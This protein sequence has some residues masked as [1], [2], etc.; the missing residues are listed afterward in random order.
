MG[1]SEKSAYVSIYVKKEDIIKQSLEYDSNGQGVVILK[2][3]A[4]QTSH[5]R[6][7]VHYNQDVYLFVNG[8]L[9]LDNDTEYKSDLADK[10]FEHKS[11]QENDKARSQKS[12]EPMEPVPTNEEQAKEDLSL[13]K[14]LHNKDKGKKEKNSP[15]KAKVKS[16]GKSKE[17][18]GKTARQVKSK[19]K[20]PN[21][22]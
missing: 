8:K 4:V 12:T 19:K 13:D 10:A 3:G 17:T 6:K 9:V 18:E 15:K 14:K 5:I 1:L 16:T 21:E 20:P 22:K 7:L 11:V 2:P